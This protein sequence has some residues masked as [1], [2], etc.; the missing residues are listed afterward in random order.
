MITNVVQGIIDIIYK[1]SFEWIITGIIWLIVG[2]GLGIYIDSKLRPRLRSIKL[3]KG[4]KYIFPEKK[5]I[6]EI[7]SLK[8]GDGKP[9]YRDDTLQIIDREIVPKGMP[10]FTVGVFDGRGLGGGKHHKIWLENKEK[11]EKLKR[12]LDKRIQKWKKQKE[13]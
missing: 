1:I 8:V 11:L 5:Y 7:G 9:T 13:T 3:P 10:Y 2:L 12:I 6:T 4:N